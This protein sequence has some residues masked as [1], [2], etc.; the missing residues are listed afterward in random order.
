MGSGRIHSPHLH[1]EGSGLSLTLL[2]LL[3]ED[4]RLKHECVPYFPQYSLLRL[5]VL[6][7]VL[8]MQAL[9]L[10]GSQVRHLLETPV[11][12]VSDLG[13]TDM[14]QVC[15]FVIPVLNCVQPAL[16]SVSPLSWSIIHHLPAWHTLEVCWHAQDCMGRGSS[17]LIKLALSI[18]CNSIISKVSQS[19]ELG[20]FPLFPSFERKPHVKSSN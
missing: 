17:V 3:V 9:Q 1:R 8:R 6:G 15:S 14:L 18:H 7:C 2:C 20:S 11:F 13:G 16:G 12:I 4:R 19:Y 10:D 5:L